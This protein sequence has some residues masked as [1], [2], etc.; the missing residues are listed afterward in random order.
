MILLDKKDTPENQILGFLESW[1]SQ[2][3]LGFFWPSSLQI[4]LFYFRQKS[5]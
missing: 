1:V 4:S 3:V 5:I 2:P